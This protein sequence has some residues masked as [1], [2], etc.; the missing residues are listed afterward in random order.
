MVNN[1]IPDAPFEEQLESFL[2]AVS[3]MAANPKP[4]KRSI[5]EKVNRYESNG[6]EADDFYHDVNHGIR[7]NLF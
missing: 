5:Y 4:C 2:N 7:Q 1:T 6:A 3:V